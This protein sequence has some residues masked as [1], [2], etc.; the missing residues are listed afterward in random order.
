MAT[1]ETWAL[2]AAPC[3]HAS[4]GRTREA[5]LAGLEDGQVPGWDSLRLRARR[6]GMHCLGDT[7][8]TWP[9]WLRACPVSWPRSSCSSNPDAQAVRARENSHP[10][11][12]GAEVRVQWSSRRSRRAGQG[13][14]KGAGARPGR[15]HGTVGGA[16]TRRFNLPPNT[17][18]WSSPLL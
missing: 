7:G 16:D 3:C 15:H 17:A 9:D 13:G 10:R 18:N 11:P 8:L 12:L 2:C 5:A 6:M 4:L 14:S 1:P